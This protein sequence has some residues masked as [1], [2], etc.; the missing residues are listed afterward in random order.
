[1]TLPSETVSRY[2]G[3]AYDHLRH[4]S[5][6]IGPR[7]SC[8]SGERAAA[9]YVSGQL[10]QMGLDQVD[11][12]DFR[13]APSAYHRY[14]IVFCAGL[15]GAAIAFAVRTPTAAWIAFAL[16]GL[17]AWGM[18]Q[19][20]DF[21]A[22]WT[23]WIIPG[24]PS[25]NVIGKIPPKDRWRQRVMLTAH[26]DTHRTPFFNTSRRWQ[27][28]FQLLF[29]S[30]WG[31]LLAAMLL[32]LLYALTERVGLLRLAL[33]PELLLLSGTVLFL[34]PD[35]TPFS[36][37]AY[38]NASGVGSVL[39]LAERLLVE[40]LVHTEVWAVFLGCEEN[41]S[42]GS[43]AFLKQYALQGQGTFLINLD[44]MGCGKLYIRT[45][46]GFLVRRRPPESMLTLARRVST[47]LPELGVYERPSQ[48]FSDATIAYKMGLK[49]LSLGTAPRSPASPIYRH[50]LSDTVDHVELE[51]LQDTHRYVLALLQTIDQEGGHA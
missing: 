34:H 44:M 35:Q 33:L 39:A 30:L 36:P 12:Q 7:G 50:T 14:A 32:F 48:A 18:L 31:S 5:Q 3:R 46:E 4:L 19:E 45:E 2:A 51:A 47:A 27:L 1:M 11:R 26:V 43:A 23:R 24:R 40:P 20:S 13:G 38:D 41:G 6:E 9:D 37:G 28:A 16:Q 10:R 49:A 8:T 22:N 15:A 29:R 25:Q 42:E 17:A 21:A